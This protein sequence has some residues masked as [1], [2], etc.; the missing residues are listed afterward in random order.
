MSDTTHVA[1]LGDRERTFTLT[2]LMIAELERVTGAGIG[3]IFKR[4]CANS[5]AHAEVVETIRL[6]LIGGGETP[7]NAAAIVRVYVEPAPLADSYGLALDVLSKLYF[8]RTCLTEPEAT[9]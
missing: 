4:L 9:P 8:G 1:F 6:A 2:P 5:F 3:A 7:E